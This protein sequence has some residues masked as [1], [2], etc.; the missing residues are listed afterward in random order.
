METDVFRKGIERLEEIGKNE[1]TAFLCSE[2]FP[3]KC[4][5]RWVARKLTRKG[6]QIIHILEQG[7]IWIPQ[8]ET[9]NKEALP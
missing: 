8:K 7:K 9:G 6:W 5:R 3:W 1:R 2:R 4:H